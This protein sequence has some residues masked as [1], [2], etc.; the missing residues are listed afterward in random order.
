ME[1]VL[2]AHLTDGTTIGGEGVGYPCTCGYR[3]YSKEGWGK[4]AELF[5]KHVAQA[6]ADAGYGNLHDAWAEGYDVGWSEAKDP[7]FAPN[8]HPAPKVSES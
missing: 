8:P 3:A 7:V 5:G 2:A 6:L 1:N 4:A